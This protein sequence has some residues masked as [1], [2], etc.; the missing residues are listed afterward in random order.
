MDGQVA[1]ALNLQRDHPKKAHVYTTQKEILIKEVT[2]IDSIQT[3]IGE[4]A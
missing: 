3:Q 4:A 2:K 1:L